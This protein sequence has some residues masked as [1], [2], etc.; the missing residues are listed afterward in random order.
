VRKLKRNIGKFLLVSIA[1]LVLFRHFQRHC[2]FSAENSR[3]APSTRK[4]GLDCLPWGPKSANSN[5]G[6]SVYS[7]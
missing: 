2:S 7:K 3:P 6:L 1:T 4:L 5:L